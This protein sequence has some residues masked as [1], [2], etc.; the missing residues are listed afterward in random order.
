MSSFARF[1]SAIGLFTPTERLIRAGRVACRIDLVYETTSVLG[2][3]F[4]FRS[5]FSCVL[6]SWKP[7]HH[8][9]QQAQNV[10]DGVATH[11]KSR[12]PI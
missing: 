12:G 4:P 2:L 6:C 3:R 5:V 8:L 9:C 10:E 7:V 11:R 1:V